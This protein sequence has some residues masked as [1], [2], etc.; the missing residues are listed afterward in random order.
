MIKL[1]QLVL[2]HFRYLLEHCSC[3]WKSAGVKDL[4]LPDR[5]ACGIRFLSLNSGT[6]DLDY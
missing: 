1:M 4:S 3:V 2:G 6:Y 5:I